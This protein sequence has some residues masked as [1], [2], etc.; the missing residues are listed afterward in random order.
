MALVNDCVFCRIIKGEIP[1]AKVYEDELVLV[2]LDIAP[3]NFG[4]CVVV[5]KDHHHSVTTL[6]AE[7]LARM[8]SVAARVAPAIMRAT[9]AEGF[10]LFLNNGAVAGQ[11]VPHAHV[12][13]LP[14]LVNDG[15]IIKAAAK[16]YDGP[17]AM[18]TLATAISAKVKA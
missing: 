16:Q 12:H 4:H 9:G 2:F 1:S 3:F 7:Y 5:P 15:V 10:N 14:R 8:M 11:V 6:P 13:I 18:Q 17:A